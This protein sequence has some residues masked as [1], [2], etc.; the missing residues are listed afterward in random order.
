M[1]EDADTRGQGRYL[2][3]ICGLTRVLQAQ[4]IQPHNPASSDPGREGQ[5][6]KM[7]MNQDYLDFITTWV[8]LTGTGIKSASL[9]STVDHCGTS[10]VFN[11]GGA[12]RVAQSLREADVVEHVWA[13]PKTHSRWGIDTEQRA[14]CASRIRESAYYGLVARKQTQACT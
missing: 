4:E 11:G 8:P 10:L 3:V 6:Q 12:A 1:S 13:M 14:Q 9:V 5:W 2:R 7:Q